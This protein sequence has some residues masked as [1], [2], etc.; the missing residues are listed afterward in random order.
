MRLWKIDTF[1]GVLV[2]VLDPACGYKVS[3]L[4]LDLIS[5]LPFLHALE[6]FRLYS[7]LL[8]GTFF[9]RKIRQKGQNSYGDLN[10]SLLGVVG[11]T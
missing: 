3:W 6:L 7:A 5:R 4:A 9:S 11:Y 1:G 10:T 2:L 8:V